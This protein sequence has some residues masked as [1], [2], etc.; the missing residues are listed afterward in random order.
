M[1][2]VVDAHVLAAEKL[3]NHSTAGKASGETYFIT[4]DTPTYFWELARTWKAD[5]HIDKKVIV[6]NVTII[7][8]CWLFVR[9]FQRF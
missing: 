6:L 1:L 8:F 7:I 3:L 9:I 5:G 2:H 4:N